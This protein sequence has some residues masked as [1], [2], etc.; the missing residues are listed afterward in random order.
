MTRY[1]NK[2][3]SSDF[4][5]QFATFQLYRYGST[6]MYSGASKLAPQL[7]AY[8]HVIK[9]RFRS[10]QSTNATARLLSSY[11]RFIRNS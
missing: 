3:I 8:I 4:S 7:G 6:K 10:H 5:L 1:A 9:S 11:L 2:T